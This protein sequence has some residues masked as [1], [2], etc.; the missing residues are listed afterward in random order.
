MNSLDSRRFCKH[1]KAKKKC[2]NFVCWTLKWSFLN[3]IVPECYS[4]N[5]CFDNVERLKIHALHNFHKI[6]FAQTFKTCKMGIHQANI[7]RF[8]IRLDSAKYSNRVNNLPYL[9]KSTEISIICNFYI[10]SELYVENTAFKNAYFYV[11]I[12]L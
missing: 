8:F 10:T 1:Q 4:L 9:K 5:I 6:S 3:Q 11:S 12:I 2:L 7:Y